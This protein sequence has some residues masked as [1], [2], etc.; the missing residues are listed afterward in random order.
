MTTPKSPL[1]RFLQFL[2]KVKFTTFLLL[3]G[4]VIMTVGTIIESRG[5]REIAFDAVY[6]TA[7]F[8]LFLFLIGI[9]LIIAVVN[10][11]PIQRAQWPFVLTHFSIV[12][13]LLGAWISRTYGF[14]G[15]MFIYEG[16]QESRIFLDG[17]QIQVRWTPSSGGEVVDVT[18]P[19]SKQDPLAKRVL[20]EE[21]ENGPG[22]RIAEYIPDGVTQFE[23]RE[24][25]AGD[26][27]GVELTVTSGERQL[28]QWLI[29]GDPNFG[30]RDLTSVEIDFRQLESSADRRTLIGAGATLRITPRDGSEAVQIPLPAKVGA[31]VSIGPE[32]VAHVQTYFENALV[33][34]GKPTEGANG[35]S[36]PAAIV[37]IRS[38]NGSETHT[39]FG[40]Q[41]ELSSVTGRRSKQPLVETVQLGLP[42]LPA[43]PRISVLLGPGGELYLQASNPGGVSPAIPVTLG[44]SVSL[45]G[46]RLRVD[47]L[48][49]NARSEHGAVPASPGRAGD[50]EYVR[51]EASVN[52]ARQSLWLKNTGS[53]RETNL[54]G[55]GTFAAAFGPQMRD[56][57]F[58]IALEEFELVNYPGSTR[59]SEYRS[60]VEVDPT[61]SGLPVHDAVVSMNKP[62]D[63][64]DFRLFQSSYKLGEAGGPDATIFSVAYDPGVPIVYTS[65]LLLI[66][67]IAWG[68]RGVSHKLENPLHSLA[69]PPAAETESSDDTADAAQEK[70]AAPARRASAGNLALLFAMLFSFAATPDAWAQPAGQPPSVDG[71][72]G[73]AI[74]A[75]GRVKPLVTYA[76]EI[77][78]AVSGRES[79]DGHS[80]LEILWGYSLNPGE[81]NNRPYI[82]VDG[83][84]VKKALGLPSDQKRFSFNA[85][86]GNQAFQPLVQKAFARQ[87]AEQELT[88]RDK[89][90]LEA[91]G[92]LQR[93]AAFASGDALTIVPIVDSTGGWATPAQLDASAGP[94]AM[95][96]REGFGRLAAA[97]TSGDAAGFNREAQALTLALRNLNPS[98]YPSESALALE[99]FYEDFNAFGKAWVFYLV[100]FLAI[101]LFGFSERPWGYAAGMAFITTG[102]ICHSLGLGIRWVIADRAPVSNMY[103]SLVFMGW[104]AIA[105]GLIPEF[106]YRKRFLAL[107]AGLMGFICLAFAENLPIDPAINPLVPVLAH[108]Y[109]LSVHVMTIMLSYSAFAIA[110]VLGHVML[111]IELVFQRQRI[112][113]LTAISKLLYKTLQVG[114]LFLAAGII[115]GAIWANESWGRYWGWDP[116]ETWSLITFFVYLAIIHARFAGWLR[117]FGLAASAI[118]GFLAVVMTYYGVN[119]I[120]AA[121]MHAYGFSEGGQIWVGIYTLTELVIIAAAWIRYGNVKTR[122]A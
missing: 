99:L 65:F 84:E 14:E 122:T 21:G 105:I 12:I 90:V 51:L 35:T 108:T 16:S 47:R 8:D 118:L 32:L 69:K 111:V 59:P 91:Y 46:Y 28:Q 30:R 119:F 77:S 52:G 104:G 26:P 109:W 61:A 37:E 106:I 102:F 24:S 71:T 80:A 103:E 18:F 1:I 82:R 117:H 88:R 100:G 93:L 48:V 57:P 114:V 11:I 87:D 40:R 76:K 101:L 112:D 33:V 2:G 44:Q 86:L 45:A 56:V 121:G 78:L 50:G 62:L 94:G 113:L 75:D 83:L 3:G 38:E 31:E 115:F 5:S 20:R 39:L 9:N 81:F 63:V 6:G 96:I 23:L 58:S 7:W 98:V 43:K 95:A 55:S 89:D 66:V 120:L 107:A 27:P 13:L 60:R 15:R 116:K 22:V 36:N 72:R 85:L 4:A 17:S 34:D 92:K 73:W 67:G 70:S 74:V 25:S 97:Y 10:R 64:A 53:F 19:L 110:M 79:L 68:L 42:K 41:P 29:A 49:A 54:N